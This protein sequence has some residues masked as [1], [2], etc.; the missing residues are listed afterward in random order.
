MYLLTLFKY[1]NATRFHFYC[2]SIVS[3]LSVKIY[4]D[5]EIKKR[6]AVRNAIF[7]PR[8]KLLS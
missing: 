6:R 1:E 3:I 5:V 2:Y 7:P 8:H 4:F